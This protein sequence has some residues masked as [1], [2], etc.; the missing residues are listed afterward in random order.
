MG[1]HLNKPVLSV[2]L[3]IVLNFKPR[4]KVQNQNDQY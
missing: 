1:I 3:I 2:W 4:N